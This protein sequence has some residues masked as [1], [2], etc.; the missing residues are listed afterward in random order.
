MIYV[1]H[2][3][4]YKIAME[5]N[6]SLDPNKVLKAIVQKITEVIEARGSALMLLS[7]D[8]KKLLHTVDY[9]LGEWF[10]KKESDQID[11]ITAEVLKG[12]PFWIPDMANDS[13]IKYP[14]EAKNEGITSVFLFPFRLKNEII[15]VI[16]IYLL[17]PRTFSNEAIEFLD[18]AASLGAIALEK[19]RLYESQGRNLKKLTTHMEKLAEEKKRF[20]HFF[21]IAAHDLKAP[22]EAIQSYL[23][24][25]LGGY[26][27]ELNPKHRTMIE[28][29]SKR[30]DNLLD[31]ISDLL[32]VTR[33]G[34]GKIFDELENIS[35]NKV[36]ENCLDM[37]RDL[38]RTKDIQLVTE[39]PKKLPRIRSS[40]LR[41]QQVLSNLLSNA[42]KYS[43]D[44][45]KVTFRIKVTKRY[46]RFEVIDEGIGIPKKD[47][48]NLFEEFFRATNVGEQTGT[49]LG[50]YIV[51]RIIDAHKGK[52][53]VQS[54]CKETGKGSKFAFIIPYTIKY[55][56]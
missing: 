52:I 15:G 18:A 26:A 48:P 3:A 7:P 13:R 29:S 8:G 31:L 43:D 47:L 1:C 54:P 53:W 39:V 25:I 44:K 28:R 21:G 5:I 30:I 56:I 40:S 4:L 11:A 51:K 23:W 19:A 27:G 55:K 37:T 17:N 20:M 38:A 32:D 14:D 33:V 24:V 22:L 16:M 9:G 35:L 6:S 34:V 49:G 41:L 36:V 2:R 10:I 46:I 50:L 42:I 45:T 12:E